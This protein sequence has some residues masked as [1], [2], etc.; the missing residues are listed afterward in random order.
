MMITQAKTEN[1]TKLPETVRIDFTVSF[2][3][4]KNG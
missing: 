4:V 2:T 3:S 1:R